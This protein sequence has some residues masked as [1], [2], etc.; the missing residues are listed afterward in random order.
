M[1]DFVLEQLHLF[2]FSV[3]NKNSKELSLSN[4]FSSRGLYKLAYKRLFRKRWSSWN[5]LHKRKGFGKSATN[6]R[7]LQQVL[8]QR[9]EHS[10][11]LGSTC[12][13]FGMR[14]SVGA[15]ETSET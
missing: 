13:P 5:S 4:A 6:S 10:F 1:R 2:P 8:W 11:W 15:Q 12:V 14:C 3:N 7:K 9:P